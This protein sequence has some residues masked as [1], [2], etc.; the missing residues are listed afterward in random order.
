[1]QSILI[2]NANL[3]NEGRTA[4]SDVFIKDGRIDKIASSLPNQSADIVID[5]ASSMPSGNTCCRV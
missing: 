2:T 4:P 5:A 1:M 3:V